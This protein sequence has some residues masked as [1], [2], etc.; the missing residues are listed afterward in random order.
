[1]NLLIK[2]FTSLFFMVLFIGCGNTSVGTSDS[3]SLVVETK[4]SFIN[5]QK[6]ELDIDFLIQNNYNDDITVKLNKLTIQIDGCQIKQTKFSKNDIVFNDVNEYLHSNIKFK[7][8]CIPTSYQLQGVV[9]LTL[10]DNHNK[11]A[12]DSSVLSIVPEERNSTVD[13]IPE[14][15]D[16][17]EITSSNNENN[18]TEINNTSVDI[19][20]YEIL[21]SLA[22]DNIKL[23]LE[24]KKSF[25]VGLLNKDTNRSISKSKI[26]N[27]TI[28]SGQ[29]NLIK[30]F[31]G[32][33]HATLS[34]QLV[35]EHDN[36]ID[37]YV[38]TNTH[39]GLG[40]ILVSIEYLNKKGKKK[41]I[42]KSYAITIL[43]GPPTA[44]SINDDG[45]GYNFETKWFEKKFLISATDKYNNIVNISPTIYVSAMT[46][47]TLDENKKE[48][49]H[50]KFTDIKS[51]L[52][53]EDNRASFEVSKPLFTNLDVTRD[54][55]I[56]FGDINTYEALGKWDIDA[57]QSSDTLLT[58]T[59]DYHGQSYEGL[60]FAVGHNYLKEICSS[61]YREWHLKI[62]STDGSYKL[63]EEGKAK[64]TLKYPAEYLYG[65][66][67]AISVNFLGKT[68]ET[69]K[70]VKS[71]EVYFDILNNVEGLKSS[72]S[73][74]VIDG[75]P[76]II[77]HNG[78]IDTGTGD[79]FIL[80]NSHFSCDCTGSGIASC[81]PV[82]QNKIIKDVSECGSELAYVIYEVTS[83]PD[84]NTTVQ[85]TNCHLDGLP[86]F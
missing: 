46:G 44:F 26:E 35:Y 47:F 12:F 30:F 78:I 59:E 80:K 67:A 23:N 27:I 17:E 37:A 65:K 5:S 83:L 13:S 52:I 38:K 40:D 3:T 24:D 79:S 84:T 42:S 49:I 28:S 16:S 58:L 45:V 21:F 62:D 69:G 9:L 11:V 15:D 73:K 81:N 60:G 29:S 6:D 53:V 41:K 20:N 34:S 77:R 50:G 55:L 43:S 66:R 2:I 86:R 61:A 64:V 71:G 33:K 54:Y 63:D 85:L 76:T 57:D 74:E 14:E 51:K 32:D 18:N 10:D 36:N 56:L 1:M 48:I 25:K 19:I 7:E 31:D 70:V 75:S 4:K 39:S 72:E 8:A 82:M 22:T 68:P